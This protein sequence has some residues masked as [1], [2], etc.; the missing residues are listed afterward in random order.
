MKLEGIFGQR[1]HAADGQIKRFKEEQ[2]TPKRLKEDF[3][4]TGELE[5]GLQETRV[6]S[7]TGIPAS[8]RPAPP[9]LFSGVR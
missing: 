4:E 9:G 1:R 3:D 2:E 6:Y 5:S 7:S 8:G